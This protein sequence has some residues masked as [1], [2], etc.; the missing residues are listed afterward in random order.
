MPTVEDFVKLVKACIYGISI[1]SV[2][3][4]VLM[5]CLFAYY[6]HKSYE[7]APAGYVD[8]EQN[9][10]AGDNSILQDYN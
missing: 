3:F 2:I 1:I 10:Y 8:A 7:M 4:I 6:I 9:T 5:A